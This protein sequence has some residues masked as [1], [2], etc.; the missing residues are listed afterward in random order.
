MLLHGGPLDGAFDEFEDNEY[1]RDGVFKIVGG[2]FYTYRT[3]NEFRFRS[4][5]AIRI[6]VY[7]EILRADEELQGELVDE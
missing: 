7:N 2:N 3:V 4:G 6:A 1:G 5:S